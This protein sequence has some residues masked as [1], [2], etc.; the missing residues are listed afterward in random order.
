MLF[1]RIHVNSFSSI[2]I[3]ELHFGAAVH[4]P[5][6]AGVSEIAGAVAFGPPV[7]VYKTEPTPFAGSESAGRKASL[8]ERLFQEL[9]VQCLSNVDEDKTVS[10]S[11]SLFV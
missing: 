11:L 8:W 10:L 2:K 9:V 3:V 1:L 5:F 4:S 6:E 7:A